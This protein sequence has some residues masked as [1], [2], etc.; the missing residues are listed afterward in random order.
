MIRLEPGSKFVCFLSRFFNVLRFRCPMKLLKY[1]V[2][3][4]RSVRDSGWIETDQVTAL[5]GEN[6]SGKSN[7]LLPL[8]KLNPAREGELRATSDYPKALFNEIRANPSDY[9]FITALFEAGEDAANIAASAGITAE[10]VKHV[11]ITRYYDGDYTVEFP[12][13]DLA[14]CVPADVIRTPLQAAIA[15]LDGDA[16][17][18]EAPFIEELQVLLPELLNLVPT[19]QIL[20]FSARREIK[21]KIESCLVGGNA[22]SAAN[23]PIATPAIKALKELGKELSKSEPSASQEA[24][25]AAVAAMPRFVYYAN[26]GNLDSE[27]Y[28]PRALEDL[29]RQN[30]GPKEAAKARTLRVLFKF[31]GLE[32]KEILQLGH[33]F[34]DPVHHRQPTPEEIGKIAEAKRTRSILM[35]S[36]GTSLTQK[37]KAWWKRGDYRFRFAADGDHFRIWVSD[38]RRPEEIELEARSTG[39]QWFL[40][41]FLVFLVESEEDHKSAILL[42]DEPGMSL[43]PL[44]QR[45]LSDFF[46]GLSKTNPLLYT[47]HS[48]F[49]VQADRLDRAR[50]VYVDNDGSTKVSADLRKTVGDPQPGAAYAV[51]SAINLS[52]AESLLVGCTP[53]IVDGP[54]DQHYLTTIKTLL[55]S[56]GDITPQTELVFPPAGGA[57][58]A[59]IIASILTGRN[60]QLP[61]ILCDDDSVGRSAARELREGMYAN[62]PERVLSLKDFVFEGAEVEDLFPADFLAE[63]LDRIVPRGEHDITDVIETGKPF[64]AQ[65]EAWAKGDKLDLPK[66]W[67][68]D[69]ALA[70]KKRALQG[71]VK[72]LFAND[73]IEGWR[74][75]FQAFTQ[76]NAA[77]KTPQK[78]PKEAARN[79]SLSPKSRH[80]GKQA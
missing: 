30:L 41:F 53:I 24:F 50:K 69:L 18:Q 72:K 46:E 1:K 36:A 28:L 11:E 55:V 26:Y 42:L 62:E 76:S 80:L 64:V 23:H 32:P 56:A 75:L 27:I 60:E 47:S 39:L 6:E 74:D 67:K 66:H 20:P 10:A 65:V 31:V 38:D 40:S 68:V 8:W 15:I 48:P 19:G 71:G 12:D 45:D 2:T 49:L 43:H 35:Q 17:E 37:F 16:S 79:S 4:F 59:R 25:D 63:I 78:Q 44:A 5:I 54:S 51:H 29:Q 3:N 61:L 9:P 70:T 77:S 52:I 57:K 33:D 73:T 58:T 22:K 14:K 34:K 7:L 13:C 21:K